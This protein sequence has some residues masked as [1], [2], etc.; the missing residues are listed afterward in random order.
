M[1]ARAMAKADAEGLRAALRATLC[2]GREKQL[3]QPVSTRPSRQASDPRQAA[4]WRAL[5]D[6][7]HVHVEDVELFTDESDRNGQEWTPAVFM[8]PVE[9]GGRDETTSVRPCVVLLHATGGDRRQLARQAAQYASRGYLAVSVD[10][11]HH[12]SRASDAYN[13]ALVRSWRTADARPFLFDTVYDLMRL[14]DHV[15]QRADVDRERVGVTGVS[16]G[17]MHAWLWAAADERLSC[18]APMIGVQSFAWAVEH[19]RWQARAESLRR[20]DAPS[21]FDVA[22]KDLGKVNCDASVVKRVWDRIAPGLLTYADAPQSL[23]LIAP[24][25]LLVLNGELDPRCPLPGLRLALE[26]TKDAYATL[27][28]ADAL[29]AFI[30]SGVGHEATS[31]MHQAAAAFLD[32]HLLPT[33]SSSPFLPSP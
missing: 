2:R 11:R 13:D 32:R 6:E 1:V 31:E 24:R 7:F 25:P 19:D 14:L 20:G 17:G 22:T 16:L 4:K 28:S 9:D 26:R 15:Q 30:Q 18:A 29:D 21:V 12:G 27:N 8:K 10:S 33:R 5:A 23:P 3:L